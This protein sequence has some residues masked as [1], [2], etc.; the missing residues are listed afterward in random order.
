MLQL[1]CYYN[2]KWLQT[3]NL[4]AALSFKCW[5]LQLKDSNSYLGYLNSTGSICSWQKY[6][7]HVHV[8]H[9]TLS[10]LGPSASSS[11]AGEAALVS[12]HSLIFKTENLFLY[13]FL[14][15]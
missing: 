7:F 11:L 8:P 13:P 9:C 3:P 1:L 5:I 10:T 12:D 6:S 2:Q 14:Y 15:F 4:W